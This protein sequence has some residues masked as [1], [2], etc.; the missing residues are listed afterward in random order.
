MPIP[1][2]VRVRNFLPVFLSVDE[3]LEDALLHAQ[4]GTIDLL[5]FSVRVFESVKLD[6][7]PTLRGDLR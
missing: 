2:R 6:G 4:R 1:V 5:L 7:D 3:A